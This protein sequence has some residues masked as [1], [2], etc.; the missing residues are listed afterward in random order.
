MEYHDNI[1]GERKL[2]KVCDA[3]MATPVFQRLRHISAMGPVQWVMPSANHTMFEHSVGSAILTHQWMVNLQG[4][5]T[6]RGLISKRDIECAT[7]ASLMRHI[8]CM[9]WD[10]TYREFALNVTHRDVIKEELSAEIVNAF[11]E[12]GGPLCAYKD[13]RN[14]IMIMIKGEL[15]ERGPYMYKR[16]MVQIVHSK[17]DNDSAFLDRTMRDS[18][19]L[20][21]S[22]T[23]RVASVIDASV[24]TS[25]FTLDIPDNV[26]TP[27]MKVRTQLDT[28]VANRPDIAA[29]CV[30]IKS[31]W[32]HV[33][34]MVDSARGD[35]CMLDVTDDTFNTHIHFSFFYQDL[36]SRRFPQ[37]K[38]TKYVYDVDDMHAMSKKL[39]ARH[40]ISTIRTGAYSYNFIVR[41]FWEI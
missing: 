37:V 19:R 18:H 22:H 39:G 12:T 14:L 27:V 35:V 24:I 36:I 2:P 4:R 38:N 1:Y 7:L 29:M 40:H 28:F 34:L 11:F 5:Y 41:H 3:V 20:G 15:Y 23:T 16:F 31:V 8:G 10:V 21:I 32:R 33:P 6:T 30:L 13:K 25:L 17:H 26:W 9:P